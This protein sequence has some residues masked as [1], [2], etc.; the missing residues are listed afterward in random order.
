[1]FAI[2]SNINP[3]GFLARRPNF[4][5]EI[6]I[7]SDFDM[8]AELFNSSVYTYDTEYEAQKMIDENEL[9]ACYVAEFIPEKDSDYFEEDGTPK[10]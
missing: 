4:T 8:D 3:N 1:M 5:E 10:L 2:K 6:S 7:I 9:H